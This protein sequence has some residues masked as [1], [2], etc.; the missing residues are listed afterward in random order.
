MQQPDPTSRNW[1]MAAHLAGVFA[2]Y[3]IPLGGVL[4]PLVGV[5]GSLQAMEAVKLLAGYGESLR[6]RLLVMD[7]RSMELRRL[8]RPPRSD[9]PD[10]SPLR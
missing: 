9:C 6:G 1:A 4:A 8:Q 2:G 7:L 3:V 5:V 10:C